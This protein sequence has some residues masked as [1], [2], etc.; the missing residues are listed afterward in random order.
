MFN[1]NTNSAA[2]L[3]LLILGLATSLNVSAD[4]GP[5]GFFSAFSAESPSMA[6]LTVPIQIKRGEKYDEAKDPA[7]RKGTENEEMPQSSFFAIPAAVIGIIG[8][9]LFLTRDKE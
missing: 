4:T 9:A 2:L 1:H 3:I 5:S 8:L 6:A 7:L